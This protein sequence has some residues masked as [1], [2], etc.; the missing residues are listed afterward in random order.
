MGYTAVAGS[1]LVFL[2]DVGMVGFP[3]WSVLAA[4]LYMGY[5]MVY[6]SATHKRRTEAAALGGA[7]GGLAVLYLSAGVWQ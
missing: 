3:L 2:L 5:V 7:A 4:V 1:M 6:W